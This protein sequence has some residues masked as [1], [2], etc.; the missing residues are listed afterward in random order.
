MKCY[1]IISIGYRSGITCDGTVSRPKLV[2]AIAPRIII[3]F[4]IIIITVVAF[5]KQFA[6]R[7]CA[8]ESNQA[9]P[10]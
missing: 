1:A 3:Y 2:R 9:Y 6:V 7:D 5:L 8:R 10:K 4:I